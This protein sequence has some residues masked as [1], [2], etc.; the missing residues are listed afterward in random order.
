[1]RIIKVKTCKTCPYINEDDGGG[2]CGSFTKCERS[3]IM[4]HDWDGPEDFDIYEGI[5]PDCKL[6]EDKAESK[7]PRRTDQ[8]FRFDA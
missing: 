7:I 4:L 6:E 5:H 1:M 8:A 2:H 3:N